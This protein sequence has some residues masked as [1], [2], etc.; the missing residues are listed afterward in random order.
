MTDQQQAFVPWTCARNA[1]TRKQFA[2]VAAP[3]G[4]SEEALEQF[5]AAK[6]AALALMDSGAAGGGKFDVMLN[7]RATPGH[8][9]PDDVA[10]D[11]VSVRV[12]QVTEEPTS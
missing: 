3:A 10:G 4:L 12:A 9:P 5:N 2:K 6:Q 11:I 7:G 1:V 8:E